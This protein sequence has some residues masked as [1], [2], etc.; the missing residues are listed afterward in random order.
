MITKAQASP[1]LIAHVEAGLK[2][3]A[4]Q[5]MLGAEGTTLVQDL[6][7]QYRAKAILTSDSNEF[8]P[9]RQR[10]LTLILAR[11]DENLGKGLYSAEST[12]KSEVEAFL[13]INLDVLDTLMTWE[14][15]GGM[16]MFTGEENGELCFDECSA[17]VPQSIR[18]I[19]YGPNAAKYIFGDESRS[20]LTQ[21]E[22]LG[23]NLMSKNRREKLFDAGL[24]KD[25]SAWEWLY[26]ESNTDLK[27]KGDK[28]ENYGIAWYA[29]YGRVSLRDAYGRYL[30]GGLR[31]SLRGKKA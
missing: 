5:E 25:K 15:R 16:P 22:K 14:A 13:K 24:I 2:T 10:M 30:Y 26:D 11:Y 7:S 20:A 18:D 12:P 6:L 8:S 28:V 31:C 9:E 3:P 19:T 4:V 17:E 1:E 21:A 23:G 29:G 27:M